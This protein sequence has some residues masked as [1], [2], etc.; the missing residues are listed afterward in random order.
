M[1]SF[2]SAKEAAEKWEISQRRVAILCSENRIEGAMMVGNIWIIPSTAEKPIDKR[3]IRYE[4]ETKT[5]LKP[6]LK[7]VG[8]K[9]QLINE[10]EKFITT[11]GEQV[12][13]K[14]AEP[15]V[16]GGALLFSI[17]SKYD[18]EELY[19]SDINAELINSYIV[20][21]DNIDLLVEKLT[22]MQAVFL[23]MNENGRKYFYYNARDKFNALQ[24][25]KET[26]VEKAALFIFLN[27][28]CFNGLYRVNKKGQF[29]VPMGAYKNPTICDENNLRN[30]S[31]ALQNVEI[32]C[33]DY[34]FS[35][36]FIDNNTFVYIDPPYR[37]IS[38]TSAFTSYNSD[39]FDDKEQIRLSQ[40]IERIDKIGAKIVL[41]NSDPKN[42]N[43]DDMFFD[44]LYKSFKI[45]R[46]EATRA[47]NSKAEKRG[48]ISELLICN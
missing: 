20:V 1:L 47:I 26:E 3:T 19:I 35:E 43:P 28:T 36:S 5:E 31:N 9:G 15:M 23:P 37:P 10:L 48:K 2:I 41:S 42:V 30:I 4:K 40:Y 14:Y 32:V 17:L 7:W 21:R 12:L 16:G 13:T 22:E 24:L 8:G 39:S 38:E 18:F 34:T 45:H 46:V 44:D 25:S 11:E 33:G 29:D 6:F 27:K